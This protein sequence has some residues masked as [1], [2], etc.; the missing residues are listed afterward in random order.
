MVVGITALRLRV[1]IRIGG[2]VSGDRW[3][4]V[5]EIYGHFSQKWTFIDRA[6]VDLQKGG[7][8]KRDEE[9]SAVA[10]SAKGRDIYEAIC[11]GVARCSVPTKR[12]VRQILRGE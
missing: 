3:A 10:L 6:M 9:E 12:G 4:H 1:L 2:L 7:L 8:V 11:D 5:T